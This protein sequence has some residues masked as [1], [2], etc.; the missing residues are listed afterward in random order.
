M[1]DLGSGALVDL[2]RYGLPKEPVVAERIA[3]RRR[4][5]HVQRRQG[6]RRAAGRPGRRAPRRWSKQIE[7]E[8]A[9]PRVA[10]RQADDRRARSDAQAVSGIARTSRRRSRRSK[11][12][13]RPLAEMSSRWDDGRFRRCSGR[14]G[15]AFRVSLEDSTSQIGSGALPTEEIP[16]K[17]IAIEHDG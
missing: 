1:E 11:L 4:H 15:P 7:Q 14:S 8:S 5:R 9:A 6:A 16:T 13:T 10:L 12:F 3:P 17:A 2:S